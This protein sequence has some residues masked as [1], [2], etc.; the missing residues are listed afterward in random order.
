MKRAKKQAM[1]QAMKRRRAIELPCYWTPE[2]ALAAFELI[3]LIRDQIWQRYSIAIQTALRNDRQTT[4][5]PRQQ[6]LF[7]DDP[8]F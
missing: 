8:P 6:A 2:Q 3:D 1:K 5:V 4:H 7:D